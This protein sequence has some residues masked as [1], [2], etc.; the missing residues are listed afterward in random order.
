[1]LCHNKLLVADTKMKVQIF[2]ISTYK[3]ILVHFDRYTMYG[4]EITSQNVKCGSGEFVTGHAHFFTF[5]A[6]FRIAISQKLV[7]LWC[8]NF[9]FKLFPH[10]VNCLRNIK[11]F[12]EG[13]CQISFFC[14]EMAWNYSI[15]T[16]K[17][18]QLK[19]FFVFQC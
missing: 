15:A 16:S 3:Y 19:Q 8:S 10:N 7:Q 18:M 14:V 6:I 9:G 2:K 11:K 4:Y 17:N 13:G 1:M 12:G 5:R